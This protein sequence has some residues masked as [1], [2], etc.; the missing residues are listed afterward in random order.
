MKAKSDMSLKEPE[1]C[2]AMEVASRERERFYLWN[3]LIE[4]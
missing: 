2:R 3:L 1:P 4:A